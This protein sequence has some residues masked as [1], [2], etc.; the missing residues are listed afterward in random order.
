MP[1]DVL[2]HSSRLRVC[3]YAHRTS[4]VFTCMLNT[5]AART[6]VAE[7][8]FERI[9]CTDSRGWCTIHTTTECTEY[10]KH[11]VGWGG[12]ANLFVFVH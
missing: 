10:I 5:D 6:I 1:F 4:F 11:A 9:D 2:T 8:G 3:T 7:V 12:C